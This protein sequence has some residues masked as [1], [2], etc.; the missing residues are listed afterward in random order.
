MTKVKLFKKDVLKIANNVI[1]SKDNFIQIRN[2]TRVWHGRLDINIPYFTI[3]LI[4]LVGIAIQTMGVISGFEFIGT[5]LILV[6]IAMGGYYA[7]L[8][9]HYTLNFEL[10]SGQVYAFTSLKQQFLVECYEKVKEVLE[11]KE[12]IKGNMEFNFSNCEVKVVE[13]DN[14]EGQNIVYAKNSTNST[15]NF[16]SPD[17]SVNIH[18]GD[19]SSVDNVVA[20]NENN[21][22]SFN[23]NI[24]Y[25]LIYEE[26]NKVETYLNDQGNKSDLEIIKD[27]KECAK[28]KDEKGLKSFLK[29]LS[30][31]TL[32]FITTT[33]EL[34]TI[35]YFIE[36]LIK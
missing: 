31:S 9:S 1:V 11:T 24:N 17:N 32:K 26:L 27:A 34:S 22:N 15:V 36:S 18:T 3:L 6:A 33:S 7:Y 8:W 21:I 19:N 10:T 12:T 13:G 16:Q 25:K 23:T 35:A 28:N 30:K 2:I 5:I 14:I 29:K 20:N 4:F